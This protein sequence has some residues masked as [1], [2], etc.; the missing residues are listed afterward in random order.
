MVTPTEQDNSYT[1]RNEG[2]TLPED[3]FPK[4]CSCK[5]GEKRPTQ[6]W[7]RAFYSYAQKQPC[8]LSPVL[9][10]VHLSLSHPFCCGTEP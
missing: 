3:C 7:P 6:C 9:K 2:P 10:P 4:D 8:Y 5:G 1:A